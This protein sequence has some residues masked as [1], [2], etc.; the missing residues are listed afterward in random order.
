MDGNSIS[1]A[2]VHT[3]LQLESS[4][5]RHPMRLNLWSV[6]ADD[7]SGDDSPGEGFGEQCTTGLTFAQQNRIGELAF[8]EVSRDNGNCAGSTKA[9]D[10]VLGVSQTYIY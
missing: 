10:Y 6:S 5:R 8:W 1:A 2:N 9:V 4:L 7:W 3:Q